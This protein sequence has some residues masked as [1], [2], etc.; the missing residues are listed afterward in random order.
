MEAVQRCRRC[1]LMKRLSLFR[2]WSDP[3]CKECEKATKLS[4]KQHSVRTRAGMKIAKN[5]RLDFEARVP[6]E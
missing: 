1:K 4:A 5:K 2:V 6:D 3:V